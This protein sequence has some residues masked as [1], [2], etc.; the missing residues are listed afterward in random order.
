MSILER[1]ETEVKIKQAEM[2]F[3]FFVV[4]KQNFSEKFKFQWKKE[5]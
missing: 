5:V 4:G 3:A 1:P 2:P